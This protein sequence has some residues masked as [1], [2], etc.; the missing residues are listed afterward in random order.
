MNT[1]RVR[2]SAVLAGLSFGL[3]LF[4]VNGRQVAHAQQQGVVQV[5]E[6]TASATYANVCRVS[7]SEREA[8]FDFAVKFMQ[9]DGTKPR[10]SIN[11]RIVTS[12][13]SAK[14]MLQAL[15]LTVQRHEA[16]FGKIRGDE[17][18]QEGSELIEPDTPSLVPSYSNFC[19][20]TGTP[21]EVIL[22]FGF[23]AEPFGV[24]TRPIVI[25][26]RVI[27]DFHT[28]RLF[29]HDLEVAI[30]RYET[31]HGVLETDVQKRVRPEV[32]APAR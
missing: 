6:S 21:E 24:P 14:R 5:N 13:Y 2:A 23:N 20:V 26:W 8:F 29:V 32:F 19:R 17:D 18:K 1:R 15:K 31:K 4:L 11:R 25:N 30:E 27:V 10:A 12:L 16:A 22:D 3:C 9:A 28:A 7:L